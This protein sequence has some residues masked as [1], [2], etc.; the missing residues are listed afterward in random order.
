MRKR[1][2]AE[3]AW[4]DAK[5]SMEKLSELLKENEGPFLLGKD[6]AYADMMLHGLLLWTSIGNPEAFSRLLGYGGKELKAHFE[7]CKPWTKKNDY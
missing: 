5:V 1:S 2:M 7:A 6:I 4:V 3:D